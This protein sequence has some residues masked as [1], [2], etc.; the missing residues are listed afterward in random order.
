MTTLIMHGSYGSPN[1][2]WFRWLEAELFAL[3][4]D[5]I[6]E[7]FPG[8]TWDQVDRMGEAKADEYQPAESLQTWERFLVDTILPR[9]NDKEIQL[10]AHSIAPVFMLHMLEKYD[11][12]IKTTVFAS[13]FFDLGKAVWQFYVVNKT[14][15]R[16]DFPFDKIRP[17]IGTSFVLY[18]DNDPFIPPAQ[19]RTF[20]EKLGSSM[21]TVH[22]GGHFGGNAFRKFPLVLELL[23]VSG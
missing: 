21:I 15:Y 4:N 10:V 12:K 6:L 16:T 17:K 20:A 18:G 14:F 9:I 11:L 23:R 3:G 7:K 1:H 13:P 8:E 19:P 5:V 22:N 2:G